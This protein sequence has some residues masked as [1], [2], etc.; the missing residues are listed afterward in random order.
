MKGKKWLVDIS[1]VDMRDESVRLICGMNALVPTGTS[2]LKD[3]AAFV[4]TTP[5]INTGRGVGQ[6]IKRVRRTDH[7]LYAKS[8]H[9]SDGI[10]HGVERV[11]FIGMKLV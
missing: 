7:I 11:S 2:A 4:T 5:S 9:Q 3:P 10:Y 6:S 8:C 1:Q